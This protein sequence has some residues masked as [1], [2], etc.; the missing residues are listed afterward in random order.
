MK[1]FTN[2]SVILVGIVLSACSSS[3]SCPLDVTREDC[4]RISIIV[5]LPPVVADLD[6]TNISGS[7]NQAVIQGGYQHVLSVAEVKDANIAPLKTFPLS[8][9]D[10]HVLKN[11]TILF[12]FNH[13]SIPLSELDKLKNFL[14]GFDTSKLIHI[15]VEG[16]T[17]SKGSA[18]YNKNLSIRRA[19][20]VSYFLIQHGIQPSKISIKGFGEDFPL[21]PN[22]SEDHRSINRRTEIIPIEGF[23]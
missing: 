13:A 22:D 10:K 7:K 16:H 21:V 17:D 5:Y 4:D 2:L 8:I 23:K 18:Q 14:S 20:A 1:S 15:Q 9:D 12:E 3:P 11:E 19:R 6:Y